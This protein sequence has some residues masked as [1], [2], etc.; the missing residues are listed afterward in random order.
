MF[1]VDWASDKS[2]IDRQTELWPTVQDDCLDWLLFSS[3]IHS[4]NLPTE[5]A[6]TYSVLQ[7]LLLHTYRVTLFILTSDT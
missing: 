7:S 2:N 4:I 1:S 3:C 5:Y 6:S